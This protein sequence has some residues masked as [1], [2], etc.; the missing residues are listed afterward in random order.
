VCIAATPILIDNPS[1]YSLTTELFP[2]LAFIEMFLFKGF[3]TEVGTVPLHPDSHFLSKYFFI[4][5]CKQ[6]YLVHDP[7][8]VEVTH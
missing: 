3:L 6:L 5:P 4:A 7:R 2:K 1:L 8:I